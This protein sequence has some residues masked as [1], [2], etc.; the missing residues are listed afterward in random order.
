MLII[1]HDRHIERLFQSPLNLKT[2]GR[3]DIFQ[4][5]GAESRRDP[6]HDLHDCVRVLR[7]EA[8]RPG[9]DPGQ[10]FTLASPN[11]AGTQRLDTKVSGVAVST[12]FSGRLSVT[13]AEQAALFWCKGYRLLP[14]SARQSYPV[15]K[16]PRH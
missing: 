2:A 9:V 16:R 15:C 11:T 7:I 13:T 3:A 6:L 5:D 12:D 1:M 8:E 10:F 14:N 4:I